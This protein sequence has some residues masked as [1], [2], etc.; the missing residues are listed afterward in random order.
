MSD[1]KTREL[2]GALDAVDNWLANREGRPTDQQIAMCMLHLVSKWTD[3]R[4]SGAESTARAY[5]RLILKLAK[6]MQ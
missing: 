2:A 3:S 6:E 1:D 4:S 5:A